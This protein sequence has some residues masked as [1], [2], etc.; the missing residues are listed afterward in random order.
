MGFV[1]CLDDTNKEKGIV[2]K[3]MIKKVRE[4]RSGF[5]LAELLIVVAIIAVLVAVAIPVFTGAINNANTAVA[6]G[7]IRSVK[8]EAVSFHLLNGASTSAT[9]YSAT[10]DTEGNVSALTPNASGDVTTV[11]DIKDKVG[12]ESVTVVVEV[13][14]RDLTPTTGGGTSGDTD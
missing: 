9:K 4:D 8:A 13:T 2:V 6:K 5:T 11:D 1:R 10:V 14:A 7:D 12:K 3:E